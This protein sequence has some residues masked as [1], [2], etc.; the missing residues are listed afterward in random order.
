MEGNFNF[1]TQSCIVL[2]KDKDVVHRENINLLK[3]MKEEDIL[4]ERK[5][6]L[7]NMDPAII[8]FLRDKRKN[9]KEVDVGKPSIAQQNKPKDMNIDELMTPHTILSQSNSEKWLNFDVVEISKLAWMK[10]IK[11]DSKKKIK[12]S[13]FEA[14]FDFDGFLLPYN[15]TEI[16]ERNRILYHH[17]EEPER[18]GYSLQ[19]LFQLCRFEVS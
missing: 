9:Y 14:R 4:Q 8:A 10:D 1:P 19:E 11:M 16:N 13:Q 12:D 5:N 17:G 6:L 15:D 7:D 18:P 3:N 2:G